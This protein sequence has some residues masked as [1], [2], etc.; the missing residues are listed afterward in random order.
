MFILIEIMR[1]QS[2]QTMKFALFFILNLLSAGLCVAQV[3]INAQ[4]PQVTLDIISGGN[5]ASTKA[6]SVKNNLGAD[7]FT[8]LLISHK[9]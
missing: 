4:N 2:K 8:I 3:G 5:T 9:D 6:L 1:I 7:I